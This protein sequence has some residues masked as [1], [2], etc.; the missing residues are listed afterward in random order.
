M[1]KGKWV[2]TPEAVQ[3]LTTSRS[4]SRRSA[5]TTWAIVATPPPAIIFKSDRQRIY[6]ALMYMWTAHVNRWYKHIW[7]CPLQGLGSRTPPPGFNRPGQYAKKWSIL[8]NRN[9]SGWSKILRDVL[10]WIDIFVQVM[11]YLLEKN[12]VSSLPWWDFHLKTLALSNRVLHHSPC[13]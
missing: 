5:P 4:E 11:F 6:I 3:L 1:V 7:A 10:W 12:T 2:N 13:T 9:V 8:V